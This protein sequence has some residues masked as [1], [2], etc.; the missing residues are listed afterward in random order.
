MGGR[1]VGYSFLLPVAPLAIWIVNNLMW[2]YPSI[3][4]YGC[5][6]LTAVVG[7]LVY[8]FVICT[9]LN[10]GNLA[11]RLYLKLKGFSILPIVIFPLYIYKSE[12]GKTRMRLIL[13]YSVFLRELF[14]HD[15]INV[16]L[17]D[18]MKTEQ[19]YATA[20]LVGFFAKLF[21]LLSAAVICFAVNPDILV[22]LVFG[23]FIGFFLCN[24]K[25]DTGGFQGELKKY[26][27][28][29]CGKIIKYLAEEIC[30]SE[31]P[32]ADKKNIYAAFLKWMHESSTQDQDIN[33][34]ARV[35]KHMCIEE[36]SEGEIA[37]TLDMKEY[38][39]E[40]ILNDDQIGFGALDETWE[41]LKVYLAHSVL[42]QDLD[43]ITHTVKELRKLKARFGLYSMKFGD[44]MEWYIKA[45]YCM[46]P[47]E[48]VDRHLLFSKKDTFCTIGPIYK[49]K[50]EKMEKKLLEKAV[51]A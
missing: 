37:L 8:G 36:W 44:M 3:S 29:K 45:A 32:W 42:T 39:K 2:Q 38:A 40:N 10:V 41:L 28:I 30:I 1:K 50:A 51:G 9:T 31:V 22:I 35:A 20:M 17:S 27:D 25:M 16:Y 48:E 43:G 14:S 47:A 18:Y 6:A 7:V 26:Q 21:V 5:I 34:K 11:K 12:F 49:R 15:V 4:Y 13:D 33:L 24:A 19:C 23:S 46:L